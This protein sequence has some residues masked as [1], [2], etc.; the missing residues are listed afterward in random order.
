[1]D[2]F[3]IAILNYQRVVNFRLVN[4]MIIHGSMQFFFPIWK[5]NKAIF[6]H[7]CFKIWCFMCVNGETDH[8]LIDLFGTIWWDKHSYILFI[9]ILYYIILYCI[10][11]L[12]YIIL[13]SI[14]LYYI[15]SQQQWDG[16]VKKEGVC[17]LGIPL[18]PTLGPW[19]PVQFMKGMPRKL[20]QETPNG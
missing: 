18:G 8:S 17:P 15:Y 12:C 20:T 2:H 13:Y 1:M 10:I 11:V 7:Y 19:L 3:S 6:W 5:F 4:M 9:Y 14:I 16:F